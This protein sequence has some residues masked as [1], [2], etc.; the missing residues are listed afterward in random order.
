MVTPASSVQGV[1]AETVP[2]CV[3]PECRR[4]AVKQV[5]FWHPGLGFCDP[6]D[7][8]AE[9]TTQMLVENAGVDARVVPL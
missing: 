5:T 8:C 1:S 7:Y 4:L 6:D 2:G 9:H 3:F